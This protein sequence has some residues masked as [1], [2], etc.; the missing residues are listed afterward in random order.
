MPSATILEA[1]DRGEDFTRIVADA[2]AEY[3]LTDSIDLSQ[4]EPLIA[5]PSSPGNV[6]PVREVAGEDVFQVV[7]G[8]SA[9]PGL[10][11]FAVVAE[12]LTERHIHRRSPSTSTRLPERSSPTSSPAA[13]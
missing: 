8:S 2:G 10:R 3:D 9:N 12:T 7:V 11:D 5:A 1:S 4:L 13:G 6:T